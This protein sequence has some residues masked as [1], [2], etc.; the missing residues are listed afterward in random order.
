MTDPRNRLRLLLHGGVGYK[1][2]S[3]IDELIALDR[4]DLYDWFL[5]PC[6][7]HDLAMSEAWEWKHDDVQEL[8]HPSVT[9]ERALRVLGAAHTPLADR[10]RAQL[11]RLGLELGQN[12]FGEPCFDVS[13]IGGMTTTTKLRIEARD[14]DSSWEWRNEMMTSGAPRPLRGFSQIA[15][16]R[17]L[18]HLTV[19]G[20]GDIDL[21]ALAGL[22]L[23]YVEL[24]ACDIVATAAL[25]HATIGTLV[26]SSCAELRAIDGL[27]KHLQR[28]RLDDLPAL[29]HVAA[30]PKSVVFEDRRIHVPRTDFGPT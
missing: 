10:L 17:A 16:M 13:G 7:V 6:T 26:L 15:A 21:Q 1:V 9:S 4:P 29:A 2:E 8:R 3:A 30:I 5:A 28:L 19:I 12:R 23:E 22:D 27:P 14:N 25:A 18:R 24:V 20:G 11:T